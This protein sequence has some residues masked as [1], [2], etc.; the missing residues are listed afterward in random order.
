MDDFRL[1]GKKRSI[2]IRTQFPKNGEFSLRSFRFHPSN[3]FCLQLNAGVQRPSCSLH[4][5]PLRDGRV[6]GSI[7]YC[8]KSGRIRY[9]SDGR[10][11]QRW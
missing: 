9:G 2:I 3:A 7:S 11:K 10:T 5:R 4:S 6:G 8:I 1:T